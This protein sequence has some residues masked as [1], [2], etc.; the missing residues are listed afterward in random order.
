MAEVCNPQ[1]YAM[2]KGQVS[3]EQW[4][5]TARR[6]FEARSRVLCTFETQERALAEH[7]RLVPAERGWTFGISGYVPPRY[8]PP[9]R[10]PPAVPT[11][12]PPRRKRKKSCR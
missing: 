9:R 8:P 1:Y 12:P 2:R 4:S 3:T 10:G 7:D 5:V 6:H 11:V